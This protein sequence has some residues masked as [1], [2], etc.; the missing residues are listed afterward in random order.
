VLPCENTMVALASPAPA[1]VV[2][3]GLRLVVGGNVEQEVGALFAQ[4]ALAEFRHPPVRVVEQAFGELPDDFGGRQRGDGMPGLLL[5]GTRR[6]AERKCENQDDEQEWHGGEKSPMAR[7]P[8]SVNH[9]RNAVSNGCR[10]RAGFE[11]GLE[12][13]GGP[14]LPRARRAFAIASSRAPEV[15]LVRREIAESE[16]R[17]PA[18]IVSR[19]ISEMVAIR[20]NQGSNRSVRNG[21]A[22]SF[23]P[24][25]RLTSGTATKA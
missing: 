21:T 4:Y 18:M 5:S 16:S 6:G 14:A 19:T 1:A 7:R 10:G 23:A 12:F 9:L 17:P 8:G 2:V 13:C 11:K 3:R 24:L 22:G 20:A 25:T 15:E